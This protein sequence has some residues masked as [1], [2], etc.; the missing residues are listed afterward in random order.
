MIPVVCDA[1]D[2]SSIEFEHHHL[3]SRHGNPSLVIEYIHAQLELDD[4]EPGAAQDLNDLQIRVASL[5]EVRRYTFS[6]HA[7]P[8]IRALA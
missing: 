7:L 5:T 6:H 8:S 3:A 4:R 2:L 1:F